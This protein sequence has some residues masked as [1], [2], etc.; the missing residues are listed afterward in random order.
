MPGICSISVSPAAAFMGRLMS[1]CVEGLNWS[2]VL[3][4]GWGARHPDAL[5][6]PL[7]A[8]R[9]RFQRGKVPSSRL[10]HTLRRMPREGVQNAERCW[11]A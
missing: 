7:S 8:K 6:T 10:P 2:K 3:I 9:E 1:S 5:A 4:E 11:S